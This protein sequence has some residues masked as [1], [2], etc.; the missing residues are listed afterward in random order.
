MFSLSHLFL[1]VIFFLSHLFLAR[2][3]LVA[4]GQ[5]TWFGGPCRISCGIWPL[6]CEIA[7]SSSCCKAPSPNEGVVDVLYQ[8]IMVDLIPSASL[9]VQ[10]FYKQAWGSAIPVYCGR[11]DPLSLAVC[12]IVLQTSK[13]IHE[14][15]GD[16]GECRHSS[17]SKTF[18]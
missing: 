6:S 16:Q 1:F 13:G 5:Q 15:G 17:R 9:D 2:C 7:S 10:L 8:F 12:T 14:G 3:L 18:R 4:S 11:F